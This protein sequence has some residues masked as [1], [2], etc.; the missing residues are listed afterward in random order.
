MS[1]PSESLAALAEWARLK[2]AVEALFT[3]QYCPEELKE[4]LY[5]VAE[6]VKEH[7]RSPKHPPPIEDQ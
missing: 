3:S 1:N 5:K 6:E 2:A 4:S 7:C